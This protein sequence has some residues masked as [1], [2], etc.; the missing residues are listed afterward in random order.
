MRLA[1]RH[2]HPRRIGY[3]PRPS[4]LS[5]TQVQSQLFHTRVDG[6]TDHL[7]QLVT[8]VEVCHHDTLTFR[9]IAVVTNEF[10]VFAQGIDL[11]QR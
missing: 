10:A 7:K 8:L 11:V 6:K 4:T 2:L 3:L 9:D 5:A 1:V